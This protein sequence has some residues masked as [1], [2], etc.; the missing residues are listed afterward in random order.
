MRQTY[1][2]HLVSCAL[3]RAMVD[4][5]L[6]RAEDTGVVIS[7]A[8]IDALGQLKAFASMDGAPLLSR[9]ACQ[10][11]AHTALLG[12]P[13]QALGEALADAPAAMF[14]MAAFPSQTLLGG[15][16]PIF[17]DGVIVGAIGVGGATVE[18]D[19]ACAEAA[20]GLVAAR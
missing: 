4:R 14:S 20:L 9:E 7:V 1:Q 15:G 6:A 2:P 19:V 12:L 8:V 11:K 18:Q 16:F 3:A 13:S 5:A 10:R 17:V